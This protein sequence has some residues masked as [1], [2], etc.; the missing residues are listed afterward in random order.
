MSQH[1]DSESPDRWL[2][3]PGTQSFEDADAEADGALLV[4]VAPLA[5][6]ISSLSNPWQRLSEQSFAVH[7]AP[8][9]AT[10]AANGAACASGDGSPLSAATNWSGT[11]D[12]GTGTPH[13]QLRLRDKGV[14]IALSIRH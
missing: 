10:I 14:P 13:T 6:D 5:R 7:T 2:S 11:D 12:G 9:A 8:V 4:P 1:A 3:R